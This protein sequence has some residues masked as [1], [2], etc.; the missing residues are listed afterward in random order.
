MIAPFLRDAL[1]RVNCTAAIS[2]A[3]TPIILNAG[4][5][6][7]R[8][9]ALMNQNMGILPHA[10]RLVILIEGRSHCRADRGVGGSR[11]EATASSLVNCQLIYIT[12][13]IR[14]GGK[15][16]ERDSIELP[17]SKRGRETLARAT[18]ARTDLSPLR[19]VSRGSPSADD[20]DTR[21]DVRIFPSGKHPQ[22]TRAT[23][24]FLDPKNYH[25]AVGCCSS[26]DAVL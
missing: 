15:E 9:P 16:R 7:L 26:H 22:E 14:R 17:H 20:R 23:L 18:A 3:I 10:P 8:T 13:H 12:G 19:S 2:N 11:S 4:T 5:T 21:R 25:S 24:H 1:H 6:H